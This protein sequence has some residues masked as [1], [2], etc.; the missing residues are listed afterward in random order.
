MKQDSG[1]EVLLDMNDHIIDQENGFWV[2]IEAYK[3]EPKPQILHGIRYSLTLHEPYGK[4]ILGYDNAHAIKVPKKFK[5]AGQR[6]VY[7]H[8]HCHAL[9]QG[10]PYEFRNAYQLLADFLRK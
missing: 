1:I 8:K 9:D 10:V 5:Y 4:R 3:V 2:K 7:D 6:F